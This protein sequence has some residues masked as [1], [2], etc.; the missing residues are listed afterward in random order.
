ML[1]YL[2]LGLRMEVT[3]ENADEY[4][5]IVAKVPAFL[6]FYSE[7][8][9]HCRHVHPTVTELGN[10]Y[11]N[12]TDIL[13]AE[14]NCG[15]LPC[16]NFT[17][18]Q[19]YPTFA[20]RYN[21]TT[22][23]VRLERNLDA[24]IETVESV[25]SWDPNF[26]CRRYF[27][28]SDDYPFF[29]IS[30]N[31]EQAAAC[32]ELMKLQKRLSKAAEGKLLLAERTEKPRM[33]VSYDKQKAFE[34][35]GSLD[36]ANIVW[37]IT[38][39]LHTALGA[40]KVE[41]QWKLIRYRRVGFFVHTDDRQIHRATYTANTLFPKVAIA[42]ISGAEYQKEYPSFDPEKDAPAFGLF[43]KDGSK[44]VLYKN[45]N[46]NTDFAKEITDL[47]DSGDDSSMNIPF[48]HFVQNA[49]PDMSGAPQRTSKLYIFL[50]GLLI[51]VIFLIIALLKSLLCGSRRKV[52]RLLARN[53]VVSRLARRVMPK[54][55]LADV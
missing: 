2:L 15:R 47:I 55:S 27:N 1:L 48:K 43:S 34:Y 40:W 23:K 54:D 30:Y 26:K 7:R 39:H 36:D 42:R 29:I 19:Y 38:D 25:K 22:M 11:E 4:R 6:F 49:R 35:E 41:K 18:V 13:I 10:K 12:D 33:L 9:G 53:S 20:I 28:Q 21:G 8:C 44:Y 37:F 46:F 17:R 3:E 45:V 16:H 5:S 14:F 31:M 52:R 32:D 51:C 24:F 50:V